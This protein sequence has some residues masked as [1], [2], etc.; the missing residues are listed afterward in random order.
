[1]LFKKSNH[2][3]SLSF[4]SVATKIIAVKL[5]IIL[6]LIIGCAGGVR[7]P[8]EAF[9]QEKWEKAKKN[10]ELWLMEHPDDI[11]A[12]EILGKSLFILGDSLQAVNVIEPH[13]TNIDDKIFMSVVLNAAISVGELNFAR[14][15]IRQEAVNNDKNPVLDQKFAMVERRIHDAAQSSMYGDKSME[16]GDWTR[17]A[18]SFR[19]AQKAHAGKEIYRA[20]L[21]LVQAEMAVE[22]NGQSSA[23]SAYEHIEDCLKLWP[24]SPIAWWVKGDIS[25]KLGN[26]KIAREAFAEALRLGIGKPYLQQAKAV[27]N[28]KDK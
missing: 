7:H 3:L 12:I 23:E 11:S 21:H 19:S 9:E 6:S 24:D 15:L 18:R 22:K 27:I 16:E 5:I 17:A 14:T 10:A 4:E 2:H 8:G 20:K 13:A 28:S 26:D 25:V 1:M